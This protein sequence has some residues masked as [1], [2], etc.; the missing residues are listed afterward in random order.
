MVLLQKIGLLETDF[1]ISNTV[2]VKCI[3]EIIGVKIKSYRYKVRKLDLPG[4]CLFPE[5]GLLGSTGS[6][7]EGIVLPTNFTNQVVRFS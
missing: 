1:E 6:Q 5:F 3:V 7:P 2:F 4:S